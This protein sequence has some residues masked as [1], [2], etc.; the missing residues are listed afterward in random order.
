MHE[1][2][3]IHTNYYL[4]CITAAIQGILTTSLCRG[5]YKYII[6]EAVVLDDKVS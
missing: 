1:L 6:K 4:L 5:Q 2:I 3:D